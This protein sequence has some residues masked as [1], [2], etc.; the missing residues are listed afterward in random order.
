MLNIS[1]DEKRY[2]EIELDLH[3]K[4]AYE[5][6]RASI[7]EELEMIKAE[8]RNLF[9]VEVEETGFVYERVNVYCDDVIEILD[10]RISELKGEQE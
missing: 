1:K 5:K 6:G 7:I 3:K 4:L 10:K 2:S 8:I 9:E